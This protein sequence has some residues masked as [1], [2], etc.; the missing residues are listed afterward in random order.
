MKKVFAVIVAAILLLSFT[1]CGKYS[2]R[3]KA[4]AFVHSNGS[5]SAFMN[6]YSFDGR[7]VFKLKSAGEGDLKYSAKLETGSATVYY[8]YYGTRTELVS[9]SSGDEL[10]SHG[11]YIEAGTVYI[12]VETNGECRNGE[13]H[14]S[15]D[16]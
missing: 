5:A 1:G 14:F 8:D 12:V 16:G 7:M 2:S 9:I 13:F 11:G 15:L 4:V 10:D 6:F 3:Y